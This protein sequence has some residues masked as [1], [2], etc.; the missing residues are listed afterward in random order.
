M[1]D[2]EQIVYPIA[3]DFADDLVQES[4]RLV[5][6]LESRNNNIIKRIIC[7]WDNYSIDV[8]D[9]EFRKKICELNREN[10]KHL[11]C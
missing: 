2:G 1:N 8:T 6:V 4:S 3:V 10:E 11:F 5:G 7:M 9:F